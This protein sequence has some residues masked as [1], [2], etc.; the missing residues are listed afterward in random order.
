MKVL[1]GV[2]AL[3][4]LAIGIT[5]HRSQGITTFI[6]EIGPAS[7]WSLRGSVSVP[8]ATSLMAFNEAMDVKGHPP[9]LSGDTVMRT[10]V[11][12]MILRTGFET[13]T[14]QRSGTTVELSD[15]KV[16]YDVIVWGLTLCPL[17]LWLLALL[18][19]T[20][21]RTRKEASSP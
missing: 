10:R 21:S 11:S 3:A 15:G 8:G 20:S 9:V 1:G 18:I 7:E 17:I 6:Y 14:I 5:L 4:S 19:A 12:N 16:R 13:W 2:L